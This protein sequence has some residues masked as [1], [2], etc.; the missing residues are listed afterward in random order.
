MHGTQIHLMYIGMFDNH[1]ICAKWEIVEK[2]C[3][4]TAMG[5]TPNRAQRFAVDELPISLDLVESNKDQTLS[6]GV[7]MKLKLS[8]W[9]VSHVVKRFGIPGEVESG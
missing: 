9:Q 2:L 1:G 5:P 3:G 7:W 4:P 6:G 8:V